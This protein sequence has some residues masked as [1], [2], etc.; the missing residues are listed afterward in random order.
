M[1]CNMSN[2]KTKYYSLDRIKELKCQYNVIFGERSN[3]KTYACLCEA[4][5]KW[6][7]KGEQSAY[8]RRWK[9]DYRG[10]RGSQLF[11]GH[12][13]NGFISE[14]TEGEY[15]RVKYYSGKWYLAKY[16]EELDKL[17]AQ[18]EPF[19]FAFALSD[20]E[21]DKSTAYPKVTT[22]VF[23]EFLTRQYYLP[24]E[25]VT[26]MNVLSTIIRHRDNVT[27]YMLGN[28][29]NKYCPYFKEMGLRHVTE[30]EAGKIDVY[31]YGES[32]LK[33]AVEYCKS[34][35]K[36][37]KSSDV[38]FAFDNPSLAMITGGAWEIALYPHCPRKYKPKDVIFTFFIN[39][40][41]EL[42]QCEVVQLEDCVFMYIHRKTTPIQDEDNDI[43]FSETY[44]PRPNHFRNIRKGSSPVI[45][46]IAQF[47]KNDKVFYQDN[48]VG[49]I[50]RNYLQ[51]CAS[52]NR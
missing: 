29:V 9:E 34:P 1:G 14:L 36:E 18:D 10:K 33:V 47:F 31:S 26:F 41:D 49:E 21:H 23:D 46:K 12:E 44:D 40:D 48:E 3:G 28:T 13:E 15:D 11:A 2:T 39:F 7:K 50:V 43:I 51:Y 8:I 52:E 19:C 35:N 45:Q 24:N 5:R 6:W 20:M 22:I 25:F 38:Y 32:K 17:I 37:G 42:L 4:L 30:M 27:I 16:D